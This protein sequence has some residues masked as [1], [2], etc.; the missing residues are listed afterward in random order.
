MPLSPLAVT[1]YITAKHTMVD[2][3]EKCLRALVPLTRSEP[4]CLS[5]ELYRD[6]EQAD[7]FFF[8]EKWRSRQDLDKHLAKPYIKAFMDSAPPLL[9]EPIAVTMWSPVEA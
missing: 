3:V 8:F 1:A 9:A 7:R 4:G 6:H 5:Y 2:E